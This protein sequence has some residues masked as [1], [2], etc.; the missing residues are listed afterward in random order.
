MINPK[1]CFMNKIIIISGLLLLSCSGPGRQEASTELE[2][3][4]TY[5]AD[6]G[7]GLQLNNGARWKTD[8]A[9]RKNV[10]K[11]TE[12]L[13]DSRYLEVKNR[14]EL[15][16][17][18]QAGI[19]TLVQLCRMTGPDHEALH[20]WLKKVLHDINKLK[21]GQDDDYKKS[22]ATLKK[23]VESFSEFFE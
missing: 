9:T 8:D 6:P 1:Y 15:V 10:D 13:K 19:D 21:E 3:H 20:V 17:K 23:D 5:K 22:Y 2:Q 12:L 4:D 7:I 11:L 18:A 16:Q 14:T